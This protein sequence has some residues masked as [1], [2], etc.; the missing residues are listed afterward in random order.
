MIRV[1]D[2]KFSAILG[3][4]LIKISQVARDTGISRTTLT[5]IYYKRSTYITFTVL[6]KLCSYL[7]CG[8][9]DLF[10]YV[11]DSDAYRKE[12]CCISKSS[13]G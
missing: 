6:N 8:V 3:S 10:L 1:I 5:N 13:D 12:G 4:R 9:D 11:A 7:E 2:N